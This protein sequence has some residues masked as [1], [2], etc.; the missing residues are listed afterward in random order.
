MAIDRYPPAELLLAAAFP[1]HLLIE[2]TSGR[3]VARGDIV[4][5]WLGRGLVGER[6][7]DCFTLIRPKVD[8]ADVRIGVVGAALRRGITP[9]PPSTVRPRSS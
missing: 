6:F 3:I 4:A 5:R 2:L 8:D 1:Y 9:W 7:E